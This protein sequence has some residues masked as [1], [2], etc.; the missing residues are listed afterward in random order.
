MIFTDSIIPMCPEKAKVFVVEDDRD[1][2][3]I[4]NHRLNL[5]GHQVVGEAG[6]L[7]EAFAAIDHLG[8]LGVQVVTVDGRLSV[9]G[10]GTHEGQLVVEKIRAKHP[11]IKTVGVASTEMIGVDIDVGKCNLAVLADA[12][13]K[14]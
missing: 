8:D 5:A 13:T 6:T 7:Q 12:V 2:R 4:I 3:L 1:W 11:D 14:L 9:H 10:R